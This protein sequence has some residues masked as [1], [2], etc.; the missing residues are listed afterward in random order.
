MLLLLFIPN[1]YS[2]EIQRNV[3]SIKI[4]RI[5]HPIGIKENIDTIN[6]NKRITQKIETFHETNEGVYKYIYSHTIGLEY[7]GSVKI[8]GVSYQYTYESG[9]VKLI[10][11][12]NNSIKFL[13]PK[14]PSEED[15]KMGLEMLK[16]F[17]KQTSNYTIQRML[18]HR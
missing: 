6:I 12:R 18:T 7:S 9:L 1:L 13:V 5:T 4:T 2:S 3:E 16:K 14:K 11:L 8:D 17:K 10:D 15:E